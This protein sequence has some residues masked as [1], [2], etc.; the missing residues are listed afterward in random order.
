MKCPVRSETVYEI[1]DQGIKL[2]ITAERK[3]F[4]DCYEEDCP[5]FIYPCGCRF[6]ER[7]GYE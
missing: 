4:P 3:V 6:I 2:V 1:K 7:N 5:A